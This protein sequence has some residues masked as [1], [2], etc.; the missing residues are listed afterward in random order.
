[1]ISISL[2]DIGSFLITY[3]RDFFFIF[4]PIRRVVFI[5]FSLRNL[6][7][8]QNRQLLS[9]FVC[10]SIDLAMAVKSISLV[11]DISW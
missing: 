7:G 3:S 6:E 9:T 10:F 2:I 1:M 5:F 4:E 11:S 8:E